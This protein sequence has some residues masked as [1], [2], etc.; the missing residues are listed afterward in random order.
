MMN[1]NDATGNQEPETRNEEQPPVVRTELGLE[2]PVV[3]GEEY[4]EHTAERWKERDRASYDFCLHLIRDLGIVNRSELT[5]Q[6]DAHRAE[7]GVKGISRN[8]IIALINDPREFAPGEITEIIARQSALLTMETVG[9]A[10]EIVEKAKST[11]DL[12]AIAM[13]MTSA[14]NVKQITSGGPTKIEEKRHRFSVENYEELR[15][16]HLQQ[17]AAIE[18]PTRVPAPVIDVAVEAPLNTEH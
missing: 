13:T 18:A 10:R 17:A 12:G 3:P 14:L 6:V 7:R 2:V 8:C 1:G 11:K 4:R 16:N 9:A 15:R 5:R